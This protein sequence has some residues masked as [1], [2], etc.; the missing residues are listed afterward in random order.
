[1]SWLRDSLDCPIQWPYPKSYFNCSVVSQLGEVEWAYVK[2]YFKRRNKLYDNRTGKYEFYLAYS[3]FLR[4]L[5]A[6]PWLTTTMG[7][8]PPE[9]SAP[10]AEIKEIL[11]DTVP[12]VL[13]E[14]PPGAAR[15]LGIRSTLNIEDAIAL[16]KESSGDRRQN[17]DLFRRLYSHLDARTKY[18]NSYALN[19]FSIPTYVPSQTGAREWYLTAELVWS[20]SAGVMEGEFVPIEHTY[21]ELK[22]FFLDTLK[23]LPEPDP[24]AVR[25]SG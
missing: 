19:A 20:D 13:D 21:P 10:L 9:E 7:Q 5:R 16:L 25:K 15:L 1:M 23:I 2:T 22:S 3:D 17:Y 11:G 4:E 18:K 14:V 24:S 6:A 12:Y 8:Q